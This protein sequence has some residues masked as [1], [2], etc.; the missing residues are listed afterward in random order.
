MTPYKERGAFLCASLREF[1]KW[2]FGGRV[3][4]GCFL[5]VSRL[6]NMYYYIRS[7]HVRVKLKEDSKTKFWASKQES[8]RVL[9]VIFWGVVKEE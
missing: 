9:G 2:P 3:L 4:F 6:K 7:T 8:N 1:G 5:G